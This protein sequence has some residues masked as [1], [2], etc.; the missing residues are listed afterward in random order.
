ME[1]IY[2]ETKYDNHLKQNREWKKNHP[3]RNAQHDLKHCYKKKEKKIPNI[4]SKYHQFISE[5]YHQYDH[6]PDAKYMC[7][8]YA[9]VYFTKL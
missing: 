9:I 8:K 5:N 7:I 1:Q 3:K 2:I 4:K 6:L